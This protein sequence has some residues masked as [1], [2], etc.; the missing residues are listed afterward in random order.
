MIFLN[1]KLGMILSFFVSLVI[2]TGCGNSNEKVLNVYNFG[3]YIDETLLDEFEAEYGVK[4]N[5]DTYATNEDMYYKI[6]QGGANYDL[7]FPSDYMVERMAKEELLEKIDIKKLKNIGNIG[8][9]F[10]GLSFD[11]ENEY[12]VPYLWGTLGIIYNTKTVKEPIDSWSVLW[13]SAYKKEILMYDS[14]RDTMAVALKKLGYSMNTTDLNELEEAKNL[15]IEQKPLVRAYVGDNVKDMMIGEEAALAVVYSG[16]AM[17][18]MEHNPNL[19][20]ITPKEGTNLWFDTM[21]IPKG[22]EN[23]EE[24]ILF[25][26]FLLRAESGKKIVDYIGYSTPNDKTYELLDS[27]IK[28]VP[29]AYPEESVIKKS[30]VF[31]DLGESLKD[32]NRIWTEIKVH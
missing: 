16:E 27:E 30:E 31:I 25:I 1:K 32:Y 8:S 12:S 11:P 3:D 2:F 4:I 28:E 5:Y 18:M 6:K 26:D 19:R 24:A 23:K 10:L 7:I 13:D 17:F 21:A 22:A 15:L 29:G 20:Y 9:N 14:L